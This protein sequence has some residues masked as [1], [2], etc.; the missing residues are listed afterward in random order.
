[1]NRQARALLWGIGLGVVIILLVE[2]LVL[3]QTSR[4]SSSRAA[5][6]N[7]EEISLAEVD[8]IIKQRTTTLTAPTAKQIRAQRVEVITAM[9]DDM[10]IRQ[11]LRDHGPKVDPKEIDNHIAML[12]NALSAKGKT[13]AEYLRELHQTEAQLKA[14]LMMLAQLDR[15]M[16]Q[17]TNE[18]ELKKYYVRNKDYFDKIAVRTSHIVIRLSAD[19]PAA[20]RDKARDTLRAIRGDI[21]AGKTD[22]AAAAKD[23]SQ[24]P[25]APKGGDI[26]FI[27]RKFQNVDEAY[28]RVAFSMKV[29]DVSEVV[30]TDFGFHLIK[31]TERTEGKPSKYE[32]CVDEVRDSFCEELRLSLLSRL[33]KNSKVEVTLP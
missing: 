33:R 6:V 11:Y 24:C 28:A 18:D 29:G 21:L 22:F 27:F 8:D 14:N 1:M 19:T 26:G 2:G 5:L 9:I 7:G 30:E 3:A 16:K 17:E 20:E 31:V 32:E 15:Y 13:M 4:P 25:S 12:A 23:F 10:L